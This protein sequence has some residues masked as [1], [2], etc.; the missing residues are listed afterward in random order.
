[1][2]NLITCLAVGALSSAAFATTW[3]VD[4]DG[5]ADFDNIQAAAIAT[6][7]A[8]APICI[9]GVLD[10]WGDVSVAV[11]DPSGDASGG[12]DFTAL[13]ATDD[14]LFFFLRIEAVE[15]FDL[16][17]NNSLRIYLDTDMNAST[18]FSIG[19][20][21][22]ELE[23]HVGDIEGTFHHAGQ[24]TTVYHKEIRFR[25]QPTVTSN[26]FEIAFG[27]DVLPDGTN[28]LFNG[29]DV[30]L[31]IS[32]ATGGDF[33]PDLGTPLT[34]TFDIGSAPP[35][36][37]RVFDRLSDD[38]LRI[39]T[40]NVKDDRPFN[41][42]YQAKFERLWSAVSPDIM[43]FQEIAGNS[44]AETRDL[45]A[46]WLGG[47]WFAAGHNDCKTVSR[48]PITDTWTID[49]N[50]AMLIDTSG[51]SIGTQLLSINAHFPCCDNDTARQLEADA[52]I[53]FI[54]D[55]YLPGG[56]LTLTAD[57]PVMISGD[58][59]LVGL[60]QQLE[61]VVSGDIVN[62]D[63][64]GEDCNP[65]PDGTALHNIVSRLT[66]KRMGYTWRNNGSHF[67]PG[68]LDF[69]IYSDSNLR[70]RHD[71]LV[72]TPE[73]SAD[74]LAANGLLAGDSNVSDHLVFCVDFAPP[75]DADIN[76]DGYVNVNDLLIVIG[77]WGTTDS[78]ADVNEDGIVDVSDL[79]IVIGNW[80][81]CE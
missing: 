77:Y 7:M 9:D 3:T 66:E 69:M 65:D 44:A 10:D 33:I 75:C 13:S 21:G 55:A 12:I 56:D 42:A 68:H 64:Y 47:V 31:V 41:V 17:E 46:S 48:Y 54:R 58:L 28:P 26:D 59:N 79:L 22:A 74:A 19:G 70:R 62:N 50:L 49:G 52:V 71:F 40:H 24:Q 73:M 37:A 1:M 61:T 57:V 4:D 16:S 29:P 35:V 6:V 34:Y 18:G 72:C 11:M 2:K 53:A 43:H 8:Q 63:L 14:E 27:R 36:E 20:I 30:R 67:W 51:S 38:H 45:V 81:P 5:K 15:D 80:G 60:A 23:W 76:G 78:P 39:I 25:G 32:D